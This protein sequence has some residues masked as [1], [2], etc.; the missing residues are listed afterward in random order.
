MR[1]AFFS[2]VHANLEALKSVIGDFEKEKINKTFFLGDA[3]GYG[4]EPNECLSLIQKTSEIRLMGNHDYA[5]LGLLDISYFNPYAKEAIEWTRK[6]LSEKSIETISGYKIDY[7]FDIFHL[8]HSTPK[9]PLNWD[10]V[11]YLEEAEENFPY[12]N[13]QVCLIG[14][15][16]SPFII[17]KYREKRCFLHD[18]PETPIEDGFKYLINI[19]S[20]GQPRDGNN[21][22]CYLIYDSEEKKAWLKRVSY[23]LK[24][25][26][27]KMKK[28]NLPS[29]LIERLALGK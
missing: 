9:E 20:V 23:D 18:E 16:H 15:S 1:F 6:K 8:V 10:Y 19:G 12:F 29:Y 13:N 25:T 21:N 27:Q 28:A 26:Q 4:P 14:H 17:K 11:F 3:V 22:C 5:A 2:D 7:R 24:R